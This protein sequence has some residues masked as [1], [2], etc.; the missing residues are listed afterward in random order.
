MTPAR[1]AGIVRVYVWEWP[2]RLT[3]W[4]TAGSIFVLAVTGI[5]IGHPGF[6]FGEWATMSDMKTVHSYTAIVFV[7]SVLSRVV[8]MFIG[9]NF[10]HWD[11]FVPVRRKRLAGLGPTLK[12]YLFR[13]RKPPGFIGHN[14]LAG[15]TYTLVFLIYFLMIGTG[16]T[17]YAAQ[18]D[19][20]SPMHAFGFLSSVF[21]GQQ[22]AR[23]IHHAGMW[24][25]LAF[26]VHH[27]YSS[28]LMSQV[29]GNGTVESIFS[30]Y[31]F[32]SREDVLHSGYRFTDRVI[33]RGVEDA[34]AV[35]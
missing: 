26:V 8:W 6:L 2:V 10:S 7:L 34:G 25:L 29:D 30:G 22:I 18:A 15:L 19:L 14:P 16:F 35:E 28:V 13:L 24:F 1:P 11:K 5:Y 21:G 32:V 31:K 4:L 3:H 23:I 20:G 12:F 27:V 17:L 9:N 33:I